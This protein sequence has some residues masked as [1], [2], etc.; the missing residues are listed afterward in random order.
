MA[1]RRGRGSIPDDGVGDPLIEVYERTAAGI[2]V[3][4][5]AFE[6]NLT[7]EMARFEELGG[8]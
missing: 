5:A 6:A 3:A 7:R 8:G 2:D 4:I 1:I